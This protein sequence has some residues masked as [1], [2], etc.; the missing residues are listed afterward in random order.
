MVHQGSARTDAPPS[1]FPVSAADLESA[2]PR[3][4]KSPSKITLPTVLQGDRPETRHDDDGSVADDE[5]T[6]EWGPSHPCFPHMNPHVPHSSPLYSSTRIIR[7]PRDWM[8][9]GDVAPTF[10][11]VYPEI[12]DN[13]LPE[14]EFRRL[15]RHVNEVVMDA[16]NPFG[17]RSWVDTLLGVATFWLWDDLGLTGVKSKLKQL[18]AWLVDWNREVGSKEGVQIIPLR[19]TAYL[20][21]CLLINSTSLLIAQLDIQIPDPQVSSDPISRP[22]TRQTQTVLDEP[23]VA[24]LAPRLLADAA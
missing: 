3:L 11:N 6:L 19:R 20:T 10:A 17:W 22:E 12:L 5:S 21:V 14:D 24:H 16:H 9:A 4:R 15:V 1:P 8:M 2:D 7:I 13:V 23:A 18:E